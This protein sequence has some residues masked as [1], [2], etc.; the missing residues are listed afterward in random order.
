MGQ[1]WSDPYSRKEGAFWQP[2]RP[3]RPNVAFTE[4]VKAERLAN[5]TKAHA[6]RVAALADGW[7][8]EPTY[9]HEPIE[10]AW[11]LHREGFSVQGLSR[12][13]P[14]RHGALPT[15]TVHIWAPDGGSITPPEAYAWEPIRLGVYVCGECGAFPVETR[16]YAFAN[17]CCALCGPKFMAA[18]PHN[19]AD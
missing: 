13:I 11:K 17:R 16:R 3:A 1:P 14:D 12:P 5:L 19:W 18:L 2:G 10:H 9:G 8:G 6:W 15:P 4:R 7:H